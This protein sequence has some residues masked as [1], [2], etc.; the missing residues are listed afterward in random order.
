MVAEAPPFTPVN[1]LP[2]TWMIVASLDVN[3]ERDVTLEVVPSDM[4]AVTTRPVKGMPTPM[5]W[6]EEVT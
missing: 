2:E 1:V 3:V 4:R 5:V 6:L